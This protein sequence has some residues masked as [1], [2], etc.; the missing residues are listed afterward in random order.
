MPSPTRSDMTSIKQLQDRIGGL[1]LQCLNHHSMDI[2]H[3]WSDMSNGYM[4]EG[5]AVWSQVED[6]AVLNSAIADAERLLSAI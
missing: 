3:Q 6:E 2:R 1:D 4:T 5:R